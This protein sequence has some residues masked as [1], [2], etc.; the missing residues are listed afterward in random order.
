MRKPAGG[1]IMTEKVHSTLSLEITEKLARRITSGTYPVASKLPTER[2]LAEEFGVARHV[3]REALK[4]IEALGLVRIRQGSGIYVEQM[5]FGAGAELF[6]L[7]LRTDDGG[8]NFEYLKDVQEFRSHMVR[9]IVQ[10]AVVRR[11]ESELEELRSLV[12]ALLSPETAGARR[13]EVSERLFEVVAVATHNHV[14]K[15]VFHTMGRVFMKLRRMFDMPLLSAEEGSHI[16]AGLLECF[17]R[18]DVVR[19]DLLACRYL[20]AMDQML[21]M[22]AR[23]HAPHPQP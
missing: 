6:E 16:L 1:I 8:V 19:A 5:N 23:G 21:T 3:V 2:A 13:E 4:R 11:D 22:L 12:A 9:A 10:L 7:L 15:L 17:E 18:R 20:N 14:Y